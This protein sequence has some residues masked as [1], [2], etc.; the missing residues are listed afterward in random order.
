MK[1]ESEDKT[2]STKSFL[3]FNLFIALLCGLLI[4]AHFLSSFFLKAGSGGLTI[5]LTFPCG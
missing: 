4:L 5:W 3:R 2:Q 1:K